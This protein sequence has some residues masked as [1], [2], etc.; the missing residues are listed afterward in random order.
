M[1]VAFTPK[2]SV[3][4]PLQG[5]WPGVRG[6]GWC[7]AL[8]ATLV[9]APRDAAAGTDRGNAPLSGAER[10]ILA[11]LAPD[12]PPR[13]LLN[14][15]HYVVS[16]EQYPERFRSTLAGRGGLL[17]GVGTD[18]NYFFAGWARPEVVLVVDFDQ[19]V[20]DLHT[21][22]RA[23]L[24]RAPD[25][26]AFIEYWSERSKPRAL[27]AIA[28]A[29][30]SAAERRRIERAL[31]ISRHLVYTRL[32]YL[33][34]RYASR[35]AQT[36][37]TDP[38]QYR[39]V[40]DLVRTGRFVAVRGDLTGK[41]AVQSVATAA[42][43]LGLAVRVLYLS[44]V[45]QYIR[46][47]PGFRRNML[48]LPVDERSVVL[49]TYARGGTRGYVYAVQS[50]HDFRRWMQRPTTKGLGDLMWHEKTVFRR[51]LIHLAGPN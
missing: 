21:A 9:A 30:E 13:K 23:F 31:R 27:A 45:E 42:R 16:D 37:L 49:R 41:L 22:Y 28:Q 47:T 7:F 15:Q 18:Q 34:D 5:T 17:V 19:T 20:V 24:E 44:N 3:E 48:A 2:P 25:A 32:R 51:D 6:A 40:V 43:S 46:Y 33:R 26:E 1:G 11:S 36:F 8:L 35:S 10:A 50:A 38:G 12:P 39:F 14:D 4:R 29:A